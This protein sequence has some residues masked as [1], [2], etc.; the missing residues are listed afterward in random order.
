LAGVMGIQLVQ[1][2]ALVRHAYVR[3]SSQKGSMIG[4]WAAAVW[5]I[6]FYE[7]NGFPMDSPQEKDRLLKRYWTVPECQV[8]TSRF[9]LPF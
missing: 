4:T 3:A 7:L 9:F 2:V 5:A 8:D 1:D 6:H